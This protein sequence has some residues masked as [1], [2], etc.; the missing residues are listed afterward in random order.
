MFQIVHD[1]HLVVGHGGRNQME[2][3]LST[4]YKT[5]TTE[6]IVD[7]LATL[8]VLSEKKN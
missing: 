2:K 5:I 7:I 6:L 1:I 8:R 3:E 4:K